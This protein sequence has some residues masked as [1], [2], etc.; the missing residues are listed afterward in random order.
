[1]QAMNRMFSN[2][3]AKQKGIATFVDAVVAK[4]KRRQTIR[5]L[6]ALNNRELNDI[7]LRRADI[8]QMDGLPLP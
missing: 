7:G 3:R 1:M 5:A 2:P 8:Q 6:S 4:V